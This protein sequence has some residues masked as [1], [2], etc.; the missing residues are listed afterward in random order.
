MGMMINVYK[1]WPENHMG[2]GRLQ[3]TDT[4]G[5]LMDTAERDVRVWSGFSWLRKGING[6]FFGVFLPF[7]LKLRNITTS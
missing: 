1:I 3:N 6:G 4:G 7:S 5:K 2:R